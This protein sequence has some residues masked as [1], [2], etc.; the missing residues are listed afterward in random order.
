M[1]T[2]RFLIGAV[3]IVACVSYL[4]YA[5]ISET[6][7]YYLKMDEFAAK[8]GALVGEPIRVAGRVEHGTIEWNAKNLDLQFSLG[9]FPAKEGEPAVEEVTPVPVSFQGILPDMFAEGRDVIVEGVYTADGTFEAKQILTSCPS[10]YE[11]E[12][13]AS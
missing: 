5:G 10:K 3:L 6:S 1:R 4:V 2:G 11:P 7:V 13:P 12:L 8:R 9:G